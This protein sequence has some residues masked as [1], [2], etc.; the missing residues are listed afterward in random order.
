[1]SKEA[2]EKIKTLGMT[3][4][5][6][7]RWLIM[8]PVFVLGFIAILT[9][10]LA[11]YNL[12]HIN[13]DTKIIA[14]YNVASISLLSD[15][16]ENV[17][18]IHKMALSHIIAT[19]FDTMIE[20]AE[21]TEDKQEE[22]ETDLEELQ[23]YIYSDEDIKNYN[24]LVDNYKTY[25][26]TLRQLL[27]YSAASKTEEAYKCANNEFEESGNAMQAGVTSLIENAKEDATATKKSLNSTYKKAILVSN[28]AILIMVISI[29]VAVYVVVYMVIKPIR[30]TERQ[31][32]S[33]ISDIEAHQGD[34]TKRV[35]TVNVLEI[36]ALGNGI[37]GF[38]EKLQ[39]IFKTLTDDTLRIDEVVKE[40]KKRVVTSG[41]SV[42]DLSALTEE[43]SATMQDV[44]SNVQRINDNTELVN[45]EVGG[46]S[47]RSDEVRRYSIEM[48]QHAD[49]VEQN[50]RTNLETTQQKVNEILSVLSQ[51]IE[52]SKSVEQVNSLTEDILN[53]ASQTNLLALNASIEAARAGD[54]GR[55]FAVVADEIRQLAESSTENA[56][57]IQK[58][59]NTV[60]HAVRDL[61]ENATNLLNYM[62]DTILPE[63]DAFVETGVKN[64][65][66]AAYIEEVMN[67]FADKTM[68]LR[69]SVSDIAD[70]LSTITQALND[71]V[72]G[73]SGV[74]ESTQVLVGDM[75]QIV[76]KMNENQKI[77]EELSEETSIF[78]KL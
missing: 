55:G 49:M 26:I 64:Q 39:S 69:S 19:K 73:V 61:A 35:E 76:T 75:D 37:N 78:V 48:K 32:A 10:G 8:V 17:Q 11:S 65:E 72:D 20:I 25:K 4:Q 56:N 13:N 5:I 46:I 9:N 42:S 44:S 47:E 54:A 59:N 34:L 57:N 68:N 52:E 12:R 71:G 70:S 6:S 43:L 41:D 30:K 67:E 40:V 27:G 38:I 33:I 60:V 14:D 31:L 77:S 22:L 1:M 50:A 74:A 66:Q 23:Q 53:I 3:K 62:N 29:I 2:M 16:Q 24:T 45:A 28:I 58:I 63:F 7:V 36:G 18:N 51:S 21:E 15:I